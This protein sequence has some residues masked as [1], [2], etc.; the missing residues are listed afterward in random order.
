MVRPYRLFLFRGFGAGRLAGTCASRE[1]AIAKGHKRLGNGVIKV[2]AFHVV[3]AMGQ[4]D[5]YRASFGEDQSGGKGE[6]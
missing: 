1:A 4:D 5:V 2:T 6:S 3:H